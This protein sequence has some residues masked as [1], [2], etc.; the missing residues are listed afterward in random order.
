MIITDAPQEEEEVPNSGAQIRN[1]SMKKFFDN[2]CN[3][4]G[5]EFRPMDVTVKVPDRLLFF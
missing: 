5:A 3:Q 1:Q 2:Y 4:E